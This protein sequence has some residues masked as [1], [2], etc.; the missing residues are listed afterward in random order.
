MPERNGKLRERRHSLDLPEIELVALLAANAC[1]VSEMVI[2][3][4]HC[5]ALSEP[6]ADFTEFARLGIGLAGAV[7]LTGFFEQAPDVTV[8]GGVFS[9]AIFFGLKIAARGNNVD[10]LG[11]DALIFLE[12]RGVNGKLEK[13]CGFGLGG[14]LAVVRLVGPIAEAAP[15]FSFSKN[16]RA[17]E[18]S[19]CGE[20]TLRDDVH[21]VSH[22]S[23]SL[24]CGFGFAFNP[25]QVRNG[26]A[27]VLKRFHI[28]GFVAEA[29][30]LDDNQVRCVWRRSLALTARD[31]EIQRSEMVAREMIA[32]IGGGET[33]TQGSEDHGT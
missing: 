21:S 12:K 26:E 7:I 31:A 3:A 1:Y 2:A 29:H 18:P 4:A 9:E 13:R 11:R 17:A 23:E 32:Q 19:A 5:V 27:T 14:E 22:V 25:A 15:R 24:A 28:S 6:A 16:I 10:I 33:E 8:V 20:R 30:L